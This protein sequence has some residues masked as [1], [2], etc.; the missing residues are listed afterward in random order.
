[1]TR[2]FNL[3]QFIRDIIHGK[4]SAQLHPT[5]CT[6][7]LDREK[8]VKNNTLPV[9]KQICFTRVWGCAEILSNPLPVQ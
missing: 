1:M 5:L 2:H 3:V 8:N 7:F 9:G 4:I 6:Q